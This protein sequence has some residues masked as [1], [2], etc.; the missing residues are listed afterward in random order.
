MMEKRT[1][2]GWLLPLYFPAGIALPHTAAAQGWVP[3]RHVE[4]VVPA[5]AGG[6][7]DTAMRTG[8]QG[9]GELKAV[10]V[11]TGVVNRAGG[12]HAIAYAYLQQR[13]GDPHLLALTSTVLLT[14]H[15]SG[16]LPLT[17]TDVTPVATLMAEYY[18]FVVGKDSPFKTAKDFVEALKQRPESV[19][20]A[21]GNLPQRMSIGMVLQAVNADIKRVRIVTISGAKT[22]LTVAGGHVDVGVAAPGQALSLIESGLVRPIAISGPKRL[23]GSLATVP[24]WAELGINSA[25]YIAWRAVIAPKGI[26]PAQVAYWED[27]MRRVT[28]SEEF[29]KVAEKHQWDISFRGAADARKF[30]EAEYAQFK[31]VMTFMGIV[32]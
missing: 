17:Y 16:V 27:V 19:S 13:P 14:N 1:T 22:T 8:E 26:T 31:R 9:V 12:E 29:H 25:E 11:S 7:M 15:L 32:K 20:V 23:G 18:L 5:G 2:A 6:S 28:E 30:M 3:Q 24:T 4:F 10:P 21:G